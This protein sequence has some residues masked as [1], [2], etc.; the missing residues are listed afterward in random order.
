MTRVVAGS[1]RGRRLVVPAGRQI[2]P[3]SHRAREALLSALVARRGG[4]D[5]ARVL[6][7]YAGTGAVGLELMSNGAAHVLLVENDAVA[8]R[9]LRTN[10]E[11]LAFP[12]AVVDDR[13]VLRVLCQGPGVDGPY[14]VA[15][16]DPPYVD[17]VDASLGAL[18][19]HGWLGPDALVVVERAARSSA[20]EWPDGLVPLHERRYGEASLWYLRAS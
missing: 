4:L 14:D 15:F 16:V 2:R 19:A 1:A 6:D 11:A 5:G 8:L 9:A 3:T 17:P 12:G 10:A 18:V 13:D 7:L 20:P